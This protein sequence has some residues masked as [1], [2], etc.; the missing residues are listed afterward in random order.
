M[1]INQFLARCNLGSRRQVE[2]LIR[3][4]KVLVNGSI[5]K[6]LSTIIDT[7]ND[8]VKCNGKIVSMPADFM[9]IMLNKPLDYVVTKSDEYGRKTVFDLLP[10]FAKSLNPVGRLDKDSEGLLI[11]TNDGELANQMMHPR[12]KL[13]KVYKVE[14]QGSLGR[15][16]LESL[17]QGVEIEG[18][19]TQTAR[20]FVKSHH[21]D[22]TTLRITIREGKK[23]QI[24][25]MLEAVG[26]RVLHLKRLQIGDVTL[27]KLPVGMWRHLT[28]HE[29]TA[30][31]RKTQ[32]Q[33]AKPV[34]TKF[35]EQ[36]GES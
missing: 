36:A 30:L 2:D 33:D 10:P 28:S 20:V 8:V 12:F 9:Y 6:E 1:R 14:V 19:K 4:G 27:E 34:R 25:R 5:C 16:V 31:K 3:N 15:E 26:C 18:T 17:R 7:S 21:G 24:R 29:V 13:E 32:L 35:K 23:R 22:Q 11:L